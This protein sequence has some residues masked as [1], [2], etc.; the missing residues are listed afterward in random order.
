M[1]TMDINE[2]ENKA[3]EWQKAEKRW[4]FHMLTPDCVFNESNKQHAV[5]LENSSDDQQYVAYT[6]KRNFSLGKKLVKLLHGSKILD[7]PKRAAPP[8]NPN[9]QKLIDR[10]KEMNKRGIPWHHHT[11]F[12]E[13]I[14]NDRVGQWNIVMEDKNKGN[15]LEAAYDT[16]PKE[17]MKEIERLFY[18]QKE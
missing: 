2:I 16:E 8:K 18:E 15:L 12:P 10:A 9:L 13:C 3:I 7:Q 4:H 1:E 6:E 11:L 5:V 17:D 14:Y